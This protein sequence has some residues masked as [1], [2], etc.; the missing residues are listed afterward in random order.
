MSDVTFKSIADPA[1]GRLKNPGITWSYVPKDTPLGPT[2]SPAPSPPPD[3]PLP[4]ARRAFDSDGL[5]SEQRKRKRS[6]ERSTGDRTPSLPVPHDR[7]MVKRRA[8][9]GKSD[10]RD[11]GE[12]GSIEP[13]NH[14]TK[15]NE[16]PAPD[17]DVPQR[18]AKKRSVEEQHRK[19]LSRRRT[20]LQLPSVER[21]MIKFVRFSS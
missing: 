12:G 7:R 16:N 1:I 14:L 10:T 18:R 9:V 19:P 4:P 11:V 15:T 21:R 2:S 8:M 5:G 20:P 3:T 6:S 13:R 17:P